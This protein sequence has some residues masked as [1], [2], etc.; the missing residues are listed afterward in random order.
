MVTDKADNAEDESNSEGAG[1]V[2]AIAHQY[3]HR[4]VEEAGG[5]E[6]AG[7]R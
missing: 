1:V 2:A 3:A 7:K 5:K 4:S 6:A